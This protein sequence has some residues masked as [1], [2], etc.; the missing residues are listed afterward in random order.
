MIINKQRKCEVNPHYSL[1]RPYTDEKDR[2]RLVKDSVLNLLV[3]KK[4]RAT[5]IGIFLFWAIASNTMTAAQAAVGIA[6]VNS[7]GSLAGF[8]GPYVMG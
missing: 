3:Q 4:D 7:V 1:H 2:N 8:V 6:T 5:V